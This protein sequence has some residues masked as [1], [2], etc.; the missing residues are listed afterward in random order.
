L[1]AVRFV[2]SVRMVVL[3]PAGLHPDESDAAHVVAD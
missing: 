2:A 3:L 1:I